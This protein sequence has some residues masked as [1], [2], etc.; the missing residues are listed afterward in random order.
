VSAIHI[1]QSVNKK[2]FYVHGLKNIC[3]IRHR[4]TPM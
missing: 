2:T 1:Y 4:L 3:S